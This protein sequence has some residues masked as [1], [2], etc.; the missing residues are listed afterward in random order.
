MGLTI[1]ITLISTFVLLVASVVSYRVTT[2]PVEEA[3]EIDSCAHCAA[4]LHHP[5]HRAT[6]AALSA[7][8]PR[9]RA[10]EGR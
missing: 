1:L 9:Q 8:T 4:V 10:G 6:R 3:H 5:A 7:R 2:A